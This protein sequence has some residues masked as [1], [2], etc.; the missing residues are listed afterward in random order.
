L[1]FYEFISI[2]KIV[3]SRFKDWIPAPRLRGDRLS[4]YNIYGIYLILIDLL[5]FPHRRESREWK[6]PS[7]CETIN[8]QSIEV[9]W[10]GKNTHAGALNFYPI[11]IP[12]LSVWFQVSAQPPAKKTAGQIEK[13][14]NSSPQS[15]QR[16]PRK[17]I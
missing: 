2:D 15:S 14:T 16:T 10:G 12:I 4:G 11:F 1:T 5:S 9:T 8:I 13:E 17:K 7:L 3:N 6:N